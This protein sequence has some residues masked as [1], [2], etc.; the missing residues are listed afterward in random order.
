MI[1]SMIQD[2]KKELTKNMKESFKQNMI[3]AKSLT[4][5][6]KIQEQSMTMIN[7]K[8]PQQDPKPTSKTIDISS[9]KL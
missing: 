2:R 7:Q 6:H 5:S 1:I 3:K 4:I 9:I 8:D